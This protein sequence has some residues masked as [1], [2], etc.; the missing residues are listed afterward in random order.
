LSASYLSTAK[1]RA[2][3]SRREIDEEHFIETEL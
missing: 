3:Q 1:T 2:S